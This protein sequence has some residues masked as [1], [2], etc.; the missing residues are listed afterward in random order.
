MFCQSCGRNPTRGEW[1]HVVRPQGPPGTRPPTPT[2]GPSLFLSS[3]AFPT[4][5]LGPGVEGLAPSATREEPPSDRGARTWRG[6]KVNE[7]FCG[8]HLLGFERLSPC[9]RVPL[10]DFLWMR[11]TSVVRKRK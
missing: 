4:V 11:V 3:L 1:G 2:P 10:L 5:T 7:A 8:L 9:L 6:Q